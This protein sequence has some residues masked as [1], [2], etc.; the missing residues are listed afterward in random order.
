ME[1]ILVPTDFSPAANNA[2]DYAVELANFFS[3]GIVLVNAYPVPISNYETG[4]VVDVMTALREDAIERLE[5]LKKEIVKKQGPALKI[6]CIAEMGM[7]FDVIESTAD[8]KKAGLIVMGITGEAGKIK[9][10]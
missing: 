2:V 8:D 10:H 6:E 5:N 3:A 4:T 7:P 9:E 1:T